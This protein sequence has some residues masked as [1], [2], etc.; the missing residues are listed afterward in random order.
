MG[1]GGAVFVTICAIREL[2]VRELRNDKN[3]VEFQN[4]I[5]GGK[6][7]AEFSPP[8]EEGGGQGKRDLGG[9]RHQPPRTV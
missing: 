1:G 7:K 4:K 5:F 9:R 3:E 2:F 6:I 8:V